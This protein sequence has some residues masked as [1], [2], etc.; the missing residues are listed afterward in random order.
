[1]LS[2]SIKSVLT[3][4]IEFWDMDCQFVFSEGY[5]LKVKPNIDEKASFEDKCKE[6]KGN[7][8]N[9]G[10]LYGKSDSDHEV[11]FLLSERQFF[12]YN[13]GT[14]TFV[15]DVVLDVL[16]IKTADGNYLYE[17]CDLHGFTAIDFAGKAVDAVFPPKLVINRNSGNKNVIEWL[18]CSEY[19]REFDVEI[20]N[21]PC[22][23]IFSTVVDRQDMEM[24]TNGLG[25]IHS[26]IRL[27]FTERQHI[28][29]ILDCWKAISTFLTFCVGQYNVTNYDIGLWDEKKDV[30]KLDLFGQISCKINNDKKEDIVTRYPGYHR[31]LIES[32]G[33]KTGELFRILA[34]KE[35]RPI[36]DYLQRTNSDF[37]V[38][39][40]KIRD[41]C[42]AF[43]VEYD[44]WKYSLSDPNIDALVEKLKET[45]EKYKNDN[46]ETI[47]K[48]GYSYI[49][50]SVSVISRPARKKIQCIY[51][52]YSE[53]IDK[54]KSKQVD[55]S[56][57]ATEKDI[58]WIVK[59]RNNITHSTGI[60]ET[61]IPNTI[62]FRLK[63]AL[64]CSVFER[65]GYSLEEIKTLVDD[66]FE[67]T[68][69]TK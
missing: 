38:T 62:F 27:E 54:H 8:D 67:G 15:V 18:P 20:E 24:E 26:I 53:I 47:D 44:Y 57:E 52:K 19:A 11:A 32:L 45:I 46:P 29:M 23:L 28:S 68:A 30:G 10:W 35:K 55:V 22:K 69:S 13:K 66:Y 37:S 58:G 34:D 56:A 41:L 21:K 60:T 7:Y 17:Y 12:C 63:L 36:L 5:L 59:V 1:M 6:T 43:E 3:G 49:N 50:S 16:N 48:N 31:F 25:S 33:E 2:N 4:N 9:I 61:Q 42:T 51:S 65:A 39:R 14:L 40:D 64:F